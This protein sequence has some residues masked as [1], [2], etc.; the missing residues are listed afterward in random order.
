MSKG[1]VGDVVRQVANDG[2]PHLQHLSSGFAPC[3][4]PMV[5]AKK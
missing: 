2:V 1:T 5:V 3:L 4:R